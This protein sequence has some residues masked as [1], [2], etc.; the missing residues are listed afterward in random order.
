MSGRWLSLAILAWMGTGAMA[1]APNP[2]TNVS[3]TDDANG[4]ASEASLCAEVSDPDLDPLNVKFFARELTAAPDGNFTLV[5]LPDSQFYAQQYPD[6]FHAQSSWIVDE[7]AA[8]NIAFVTHVGDIVHLAN[9]EFEWVTTDAALSRLEDPATT[10]LPDGIPYGLAV[11]NHDQSPNDNPGTIEDP[12]G[13]TVLYNQYFGVDRFEERSYWGGNFGDNNDNSYQYF[14]AGGMDFIVLHLE[15]FPNINNPLFYATIDW[16]DDVLKAHP[17]HRAILTSHHLLCPTQT[18][19]D[20]N[21]EGPFSA[22]GQVIYD[23]L[24][25]NPNLFLMPNGHGGQPDLMVRRVDTFNG[26]TIH[27]LMSNYHHGEHCPF[28]CGNGYLRIMTFEPA[29][30]RIGVETYS[31]SLDQYKTNEFSQFTLDYDMN[32]GRHFQEIGTLAGVSSGLSPCINWT[33]RSDG[34]E[35]EWYVEVDDGA[36][37]TVSPRWTFTSDGSCGLAGECDD[38]DPCTHDG[39]TGGTCENL[40]LSGCCVVDDDCDDGNWCTTNSCT[41]G[42]CQ[43]SNN[44]NACDDGVA[45]T[46]NDVCG[47]GNCAGSA[48][49]CDDLN[50]CTQEICVDGICDASYVPSPGCCT[51]DSEC[52]DENPCTVDSCVGA[53]NCE[54]VAVPGCCLDSTECTDA[55]SCTADICVQRNRGAALLDQP[56]DYISMA[57]WGMGSDAEL[58]GLNAATFTLECWF[59]WSGEGAPS[60]TAGYPWWPDP[61]G[62]QTFPIMAKGIRGSEIH[63]NNA[64]MDGLTSV[65]YHVGIGSVSNVIEADFEE[66]PSQPNPA[67]NHPVYGTTVI[68]PDVWHHLAVTYDGNC[69]QIYLDGQ[70]DTDGTNC[71]GVRPADESMHFFSLGVGQGWVGEMRG[72]FG[73]MI[74]EARVWRRALSQGEI[75]AQMFTQIRSDHD[76]LARWDLDEVGIAEDTTGN[77]N[78]GVFV[79]AGVETLNIPDLGG[80]VCANRTP[81]EVTELILDPAIKCDFF[82]CDLPPQSTKLRWLEPSLANL[83]YDVVSGTIGELHADGGTEFA[84]CLIDDTPGP[85][86][87]DYRTA[88]PSGETYYYMVREQGPCA[89]GTYGSATGGAERQPGVG[90]P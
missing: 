46:E 25:D 16:A 89:G 59:N 8:R 47:G 64:W 84:E 80:R 83:P 22:T 55:D 42:S 34:A 65:N 33:G 24:K 50:S 18:C 28:L 58:P 72:Y 60:D 10:E 40:S 31:P 74:D 75:Q 38:G 30:D 9:N 73:G 27:T 71:P 53:T 11:G 21:I 54:N 12:A 78:I 61:G 66:H 86:Y 68:M 15:F 62:I 35:Y 44:T 85:Y 70:P 13:T 57:H 41:G 81:V 37:T 32:S 77:R 19:P 63:P 39:C 3:P 4:V 14:S 69:W 90:C 26:N 79:G 45:C 23:E 76:L 6:I 29:L 36:E 82:N 20:G 1:A 2:P 48:I 5:V 56:N 51:T 52:E 7:R 67:V 88:P 87:R 17:D 43:T 49:V